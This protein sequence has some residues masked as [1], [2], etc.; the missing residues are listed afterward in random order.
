MPKSSVKAAARKISAED[1]AL[2]RATARVR[3]ALNSGDEKKIAR[4]FDHATSTVDSFQNFAAGL[5]MGSQNIL[6]G[7]TYGF[8]PITR[9]RTLCEWIHRGSWL[10]GVVVDI[11]ADDMTR[12]G[13]SIK[14]ELD[15]GDIKDIQ[16]YAADAGVWEALNDLEKWARL[17]GGAIS[18]MLVDGQDM[19]RPFQW[20]RVGKNQ[21]RGMLTL[22]R[23][24][25]E[26]SLNDLVTEYGPHFNLPKFYRV[27]GEFP[28]L[29]GKQVHYSRVIR[30]EGIRLPYWQRLMEN[31]WGISVYE[32]MYDRMVAFDSASTGAAQLTYKSHLRTYKLDGLR[33]IVA[34][35]GPALMGLTRFVN[36]MRLTQ[37]NEGIT[38]IDGKDDFDTH[39]SASAF[40]GLNEILLQFGM[41]VAGA[42]EMPLV[43][44]FGQSPAGLNATGESDI[45]NYYDGIRAKQNRHVRP[46]VTNV[47]KAICMSMGI[48]PPKDFGVE[49]NPLWQMTHKEKA[50]TASAVAD[51]LDKMSSVMSDRTKLN[52]FKQSSDYTGI[53]SNITDEEMEAASELPAPPA[54]ETGVEETGTEPPERGPGALDSN[55]LWDG[56]V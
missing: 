13:V 38:L 55:D 29:Y 17:Y 43:K 6:S 39:S 11:V 16:T 26:P 3:A 41:Q 23:W 20:E 9:E 8:N 28:P 15:P 33:T 36:F 32:R 30:R 14:G 35:G 31:L 10:G 1:R 25:V 24:A 5:G 22:D 4:A 7:S 37:S 46:G 44:L 53:G 2:R 47:Y 56:A 50:E 48:K 18:I 19:S 34:G 49:F 52:E 40:S 21:F 12:E 51:A 54:E 27:T 42:V 45:R